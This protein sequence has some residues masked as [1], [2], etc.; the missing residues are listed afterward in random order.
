MSRLEMTGDSVR[1]TLRIREW[2]R[3]NGGLGTQTI[4][5]AQVYRMPATVRTLLVDDTDGFITVILP[6]PELTI[7]LDTRVKLIGPGTSGVQIR[8]AAGRIDNAS[9]LTITTSLV[10]RDFHSDGNNYWIV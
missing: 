2:E 10:S 4:R 3:R 8:P 1:D 5:G 7:G 9:V 6:N